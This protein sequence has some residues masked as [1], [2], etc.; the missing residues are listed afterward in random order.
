MPVVVDAEYD[1]ATQ[2]LIRVSVKDIRKIVQCISRCK[3]PGHDG[4]SVKHLR[5]VGMQYTQSCLCHIHCVFIFTT[6]F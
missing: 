4:L 6:R 3:S 1:Q 2:N 5:H